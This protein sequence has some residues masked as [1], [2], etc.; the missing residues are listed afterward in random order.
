MSRQRAPGVY[1]QSAVPPRGVSEVR[2]DIAGF[3]GVSK[4]GPL[5]EPVRI[6]N[7]S[8]FVSRFG[9]AMPEGFLAYAVAGFFANGGQIC[10]VVRVGEAR[11]PRASLLLVNSACEPVFRVIAK[12]HGPGTRLISVRVEPGIYGRFTLY[13]EVAGEVTEVWRDLESLKAEDSQPDN[14]RYA[15]ELLGRSRT[16]PS[17]MLDSET[18]K[19]PLSDSMLIELQPLNTH[20][21]DRQPVAVKA[22]SRFVQ[23]IL[24]SN[25]TGKGMLSTCQPPERPARPRG[26]LGDERGPS[27]VLWNLSVDHFTGE[28][29][30]PGRQWGLQTLEQ[31]DEVA[32][33]AIPDLLWPGV[34][35]PRKPDP[36]A[37]RCHVVPAEPDPIVPEPSS[38]AEGRPLLEH[39]AQQAQ[40]LQGHE[41]MIRHC[42][43]L[44]DRFAILEAPAGLQPD[45]LLRSA[46]PSLDEKRW[47]PQKLR[48][49][50]AQFSGLYYPWVYV[51]EPLGTEPVRLVPP[52]GQ[53]A[54]MFARV[55]LSTGVQKPPASEVLDE[56]RGV[57]FEIDVEM[58][59]WLNDENI[60]AIRP[61][62]ARGVRVMGA[63]TLVDPR[64][65]ELKPWRYI[66]VRRLVMMI[67]ESLEESTQW[68][69]F[70]PNTADK[71]R[72]LDRAV[73]TYL[74][75]QWR[76]GRL[77]GASPEEAF[78]VTCDETT[79]SSVDVD[80][81]R[82]T[83]VISLRPPPP[84]EFL[85][86]YLG[87]RFGETGVIPAGGLTNA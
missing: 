54:G 21:D 41:A 50:A 48:S 24:W 2:T 28:N 58:H 59:G 4:R 14:P 67:E 12:D 77:D 20:L 17:P 47:H 1:F 85:I 65:A 16:F 34:L 68:V 45:D 82:M 52:G 76:I 25:E 69:V 49:E 39:D 81:G 61:L 70:E 43:K 30:K 8:Q 29:Q 63:R 15:L 60:N 26:Y 23:E 74:E 83:C 32:I 38:I 18:A 53:I 75:Q 37:L 80:N 19:R 57:E 3:V 79:N 64:L 7:W 40:Y 56:V 35:P 46:L 31:V 73:R 9:G 84:S 33:I 44:R 62:P 78:T 27:P 42:A 6:Q 5:H 72:E 86:V 71:R 51:P 22:P 87:H 36:P 55:D 66:H 10:Y 11:G 13:V